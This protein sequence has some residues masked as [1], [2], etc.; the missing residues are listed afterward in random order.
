MYFCHLFLSVRS[1]Q[2]YNVSLSNIE[3]YFDLL[4]FIYKQMLS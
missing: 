3:N 4:A 1:L 2:I